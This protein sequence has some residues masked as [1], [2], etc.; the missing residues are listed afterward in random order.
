MRRRPRSASRA[1][2]SAA[3]G[4]RPRSTS[5]DNA[6]RALADPQLQ[7][8]LGQAQGRLRREPRAAAAE[9]LPEFEALRDR[10]ARHQEPHAG[11]P[12]S[13]P[14]GVRA[15][16]RRAAAATS[17]GRRRRRGARRSCSTSAAAAG[18]RTV[19][20]TKSDDR[21]GDRP[22]RPPRGRRASQPVETDLG[23]YIIQLADEPPSHIIAPAVHLTKDQV[24]D[25]FAQASRSWPTGRDE[26][27]DLVAEARACP[28][29]AVT[30]R[31]TSA[32]PAPIS[33]SP[34]PARRSS[35][36]TRATPI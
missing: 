26:A 33:W 36:P 28:A 6:T 13:L 32:S 3:D 2:V 18:A 20:K 27:A 10:G 15:Q 23:E 4:S 5:S 19:T 29:R 14:R 34:R 9:R 35:S 30:S 21:R 17:T 25:L 16:G 12:R 1:S 8:A 7:E 11:Q 24:A 22:Q 31:P